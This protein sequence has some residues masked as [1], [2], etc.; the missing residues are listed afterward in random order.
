MKIAFENDK[1]VLSDIDYELMQTILMGITSERKRMT[2]KISN[3]SSCIYKDYTDEQK[4]G[5]KVQL[6]YIKNKQKEL[7]EIV[8]FCNNHIDNMPI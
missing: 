3:L 2:D 1:F 6:D 5:F 8:D 4:E 7:N